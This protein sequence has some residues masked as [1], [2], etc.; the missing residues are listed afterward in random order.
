MNTPIPEDK[1]G[2]IRSALFRGQKIE[3]IKLYRESADMGLA[4][5]KTAV[6]RLEVELRA[7]EP[8]KFTSP[9]SGKGCLGVVAMA[10]TVVSVGIGWWIRG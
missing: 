8:E 6:E 9:A 10:C 4:E 5:A 2:Q 7:S 1:L 3:A